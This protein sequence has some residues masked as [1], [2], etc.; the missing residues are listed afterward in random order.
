MQKI[1]ENLLDELIDAGDQI[2]DSVT[3][4]AVGLHPTVPAVFQTGNEIR[5][6]KTSFIKDD[7]NPSAVGEGDEVDA[8]VDLAASVGPGHD[9]SSSHPIIEYR[10]FSEKCQPAAAK[11]SEYFRSGKAPKLRSCSR[12]SRSSVE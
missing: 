12:I 2:S 3:F 1:L 9:I 5:V 6:P 4:G 10:T 8:G 7:A 11:D